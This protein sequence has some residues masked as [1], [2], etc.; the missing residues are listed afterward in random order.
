VSE[1]SD[2]GSD[3]SLPA[4]RVDTRQDVSRGWVGGV[5][6]VAVD[7]VGDIVLGL[8]GAFYVVVVYYVVTVLVGVVYRAVRGV[9]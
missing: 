4:F 8:G 1:W 7:V 9:E 3:S 5:V 6:M 2:R